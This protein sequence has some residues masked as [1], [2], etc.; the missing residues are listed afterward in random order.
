[1][2]PMQ[3]LGDAQA[4][5]VLVSGPV[6]AVTHWPVVVSQVCPVEQPVVSQDVVAVTHWPVALS[7]V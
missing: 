4:A 2:P 5:P 3:S 7:Q 6:A 1:M